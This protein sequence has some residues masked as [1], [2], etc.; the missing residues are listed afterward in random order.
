MGYNS[1]ADTIGL[2]SFVLPWWSPKFAKSREIPTK[3]DLTAVQG[4]PRSSILVS[5]ES[6]CATSYWSLIVTLAISATVFEILR[7]KGRK[8]P[9]FNTPPFFG[10]PARG[11]NPS[12]L[13]DEIWGQKTTVLGLSDGEEIMT[14]AFFVLTQYRLVTDGRTDRHVAIA[15]TRASIALRG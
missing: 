11:G 5:I 15:I 9:N 6:P 1:V 7:L 4:H 13:G 3:C 2:S 14:L 8:S 12:E 10:A